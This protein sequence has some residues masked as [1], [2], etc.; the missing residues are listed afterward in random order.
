MA[1]KIDQTTPKSFE[2]HK[3][4]QLE[5]ARRAIVSKAKS[6]IQKTRYSL[7]LQQ[8]KIVLYALS[9]IQPGD[10]AFTEY[11]FSIKDFCA[12][13]GVE[14]T[15]YEYIKKT[16]QSL[17]RKVFWI[18]ID[19]KGT[20]SCVDWFSTIHMNKRSGIVMM[21]FHEDLHPFLLELQSNFLSFSIF[22]TLA[23]KSRYSI[24]LYELLKS[25][26]NLT[27][28]T[29]DIPTLKK[30]LDAEKYNRYADFRRNVLDV[31][32]AEINKFSDLDISYESRKDGGREYA[33]IQFFINHKAP[34]FKMEADQKVTNQIKGQLTFNE[35]GD[36]DG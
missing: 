6:M 22:P 25:Y 23:M 4:E 13:C 30:K 3:A 12:L 15:N 32:I 7:S 31:S 35:K 10:T 19:E 36:D 14:P 17:R 8:Q 24:R 26:Q 29:F 9:K 11:K 33:I 21:K 2:E 20:E 28:W 18:T 1:K 34:F 27:E 16:M 5:K